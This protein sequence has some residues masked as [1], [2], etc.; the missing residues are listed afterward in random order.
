[1]L[2]AH[3]CPL[4]SR[5]KGGTR[6]RSRRFRWQWQLFFSSKIEETKGTAVPLPPLTK[7]IHWHTR[8]KRE[9]ALAKHGGKQRAHENKMLRGNEIWEKAG[10]QYAANRQDYRRQVRCQFSP[11]GVLENDWIK[12]D[13][14]FTS[15]HHTFRYGDILDWVTLSETYTENTTQIN[16]G[17]TELAVSHCQIL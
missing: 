15:S 7:S 14:K 12:L 1:M 4:Y 3:T 16:Q 11:S 17:I 13:E 2:H 5:H 8:N 10:R 6:G 9:G